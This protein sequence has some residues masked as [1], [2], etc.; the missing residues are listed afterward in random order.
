MK[1]YIGLAYDIGKLVT[2]KQKAYGDSYGQSSEFLKL[3]WPDGVPV[4]CYSDLLCVVRIFDKLKR[5]ATDKDWSG[6][7]PYKDIAGYALLSLRKDLVLN[8]I[9]DNEEIIKKI[10]FPPLTNE[11]IGS[12]LPPRDKRKGEANKKGRT[13]RILSTINSKSK[14]GVKK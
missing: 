13:K 6:E 5:I 7:S 1:S 12:I 14:Q 11:E 10:E 4:D 8:D 9:E 3:L 2:Q